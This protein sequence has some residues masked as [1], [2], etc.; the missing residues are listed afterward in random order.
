MSTHSHPTAS[1]PLQLGDSFIPAREYWHDKLEGEWR[2]LPLHTDRV[3]RETGGKP[4][5]AQRHLG[6]EAEVASRLDALCKGKDLLTFV[7]FSAAVKILFSKLTGEKE[8]SIVS[9][10]YNAYPDDRKHNFAVLLNTCLHGDW[11]FKQGLKEVNQT[12]SEAYKHQYYPI[13]SLTE[14]LGIDFADAAKI[15]CDYDAIHDHPHLQTDL[16]SM[17]YALRFQ[18]AKQDNSYGVTL[19]Y[20]TDLFQ[21]A[22]AEAMLGALAQL[23]GQASASPELLLRELE[24]VG[25]EEQ[26]RM[27]EEQ[28]DD[29]QPEWCDLTIPDLFREQVRLAPD[30]TALVFEESSWTYSQLDH[31]S[32]QWAALLHSRDV[33]KGAIVGLMMER[34]AEWV[35][36]VLAVLKAGAA[37]LPLDPAYPEERLNH[38]LQ[39]S[40]CELV[41]ISDSLTARAAELGTD[42][43]FLSVSELQSALQMADLTVLNTIEIQA[44]D[45]SY[46]IYT[47]GSTGK[48]KGVLLEHQGMVNLRESFIHLLDI[49]SDDRIIQFASSSF[50]ASAWETFMALL[51]GAQ[52]HM[53]RKEI[54]EDFTSFTSYMQRQR[55][56]VATLPP[57][58]AIHLDPASLPDMRL[59]VTAGSAS[60][61]ELVERWQPHLQYVNAYGPTETTI[62]ATLWK[63][64]EST[65]HETMIPIGKPLLYTEVFIL[66][67]DG[68]MV[69]PG[70]PGE[71]CVSSRGLARGYHQRPEL[72]EQVFVPHPFALCKRMY[73]TGDLA[74]YLPDGNIEYLGRLDHQVKIRGFRVEIGEIES[75]LQSLN[76]V[77]NSLVMDH[78]RSDGSAY[79]CGYVEGKQLTASQLQNGLLEKLP[80]YMIP[81]A[82]VIV[83]EMPLTPNGKMDRQALKELHQQQRESR[84]DLADGS[85]T[86]QRLFTIWAQLLERHDFGLDDPFFEIGGQSLKAMTLIAEIHRTFQ[87]QIRI[88]DLLEAQTIRSLAA[89]IEARMSLSDSQPFNV[90]I[91]KAPVQDTYPLSLAQTR[92]FILSQHEDTGLTYNVPT[93]LD[94]S[95]DLQQD[96]LQAAFE[97]LVKRHESLRTTFEW[98][99]GEPVQRI[100]SHIPVQVDVLEGTAAESRNKLQTYIQPFDLEKGPLFR[101]VLM[102][103]GPEQ[104]TLLIDMH[105]IITD[106]VSVGRLLEDLAAL[107]E[108]TK[109]PEL[110]IQYKDFAYWQQSHRESEVFQQ[111][112][113]FWRQQFELPVEPLNLGQTYVPD[114]MMDTS[115]ERL[116][117]TLDATLTGKLRDFCQ[118]HDVTLYMLLLGIYSC[119]LSKWSAQSDIVVGTPVAG[120]SLAELQDVVGMF[121]NILPLRT[122]ISGEDSFSQTMQQVKNHVWQAFEHQDYPFDELVRKL[123]VK[124]VQG[125]NPLFD[126]SFA[127]QNMSF[128]EMRFGDVKLAPQPVPL[129][130]A[131]FDLTLWAV[132]TETEIE[133]ELEYAIYR[134]K[135]E[136][137]ESFFQAFMTVLEQVVEHPERPLKE[138]DIVDE[139]TKQSVMKSIQQV[140]E[141]MD[142]DF[143]F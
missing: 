17:P 104:G 101:V 33:G 78:Q 4:A 136:T 121:V 139:A 9:P 130:V 29:Q 20:R 52:L 50:D 113:Q 142:I 10:V 7:A 64:D 122:A 14:E 98:A 90:A 75:R 137:V 80:D 53:V 37:Y 109:L 94:F 103:T 86:E 48:P 13:G 61:S 119:T 69:P 129:S 60:S 73:R 112:E 23:L 72:T 114:K 3:E 131:K 118:T 35:C 19:H 116:N 125:R 1:Q 134:F 65:D 82:W 140:E 143:D 108:G 5:Y 55:I 141:V 124:R 132:E 91:S 24:L 39:D 34:S 123:Q 40:G 127:L 42:T 100:H 110:A 126:A 96:K 6:M 77:T 120:R 115:G 38:M 111:D 67:A 128:P 62:C 43:P 49:S 28:H 31:W 54:I 102:H 138:V 11:S 57:T 135:K 93:L 44:G 88:P 21:P 12:V 15:V 105:H 30:H 70:L 74:K 76:G 92:L 99:Q 85:E 95:G 22:S 79:L 89:L 81:E 84:V 133:L 36:A 71:L 83:D 56:T 87:C 2:S 25:L 26:E 16:E 58:Y 68:Q 46:I 59:L 45:L 32:D 107:Y 97:E 18:W 66:T 63:A 117:Q 51:T 106:G 27:L 47:S 8:V 41:L